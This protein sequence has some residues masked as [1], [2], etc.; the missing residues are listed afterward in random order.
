MQ[1]SRR[2]AWTLCHLWTGRGEGWEVHIDLYSCC[3]HVC[4]CLLDCSL[5]QLRIAV[6]KKGEVK[7]PF[8]GMWSNTDLNLS[9]HR[10]GVR[11]GESTWARVSLKHVRLTR[12]TAQA[13]GVGVSPMASNGI[14]QTSC[15]QF[16]GAGW[17]RRGPSRSLRQSTPT[18][19][20]PCN[21][22]IFHVHSL[23]G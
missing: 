2:T 20:S 18:G 1:D 6:E 22:S 12:R 17:E 23:A 3:L 10:G 15:Q 11:R 9:S 14:R 8:A 16:W 4:W 19:F 21:A 13:S 7:I 5:A